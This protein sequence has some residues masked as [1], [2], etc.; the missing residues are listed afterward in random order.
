[1]GSSYA[2]VEP[3]LVIHM[4]EKLAMSC[5]RGILN[6]EQGIMNIEGRRSE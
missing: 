6:K 2:R 3:S 1:V 4:E 5:E